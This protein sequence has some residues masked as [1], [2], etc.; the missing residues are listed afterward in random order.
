MNKKSKTVCYLILNVAFSIL[1]VLLNKWLYVRVGFPN[2][3]LS[4]IHFLVTY[5]GLLICERLNVF[6]IKTVPIQ[7]MI[8]IAMT[9]CGFVVLTNLS[10]GHNTVGTYQVA[11][12]LTTPCVIGMQMI[13]YKK[14]YSLLIKLTLLPIIFGV[15]INFYYDIKFNVLGTVFAALGVVV[16]SIY[17]IVNKYILLFLF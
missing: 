2:I 13:I 4:F 9:F 6:C 11:K 10:L 17:Q 8:L 15:V 14:D 12:M 7:G 1:I 3:T 16:T 5:A